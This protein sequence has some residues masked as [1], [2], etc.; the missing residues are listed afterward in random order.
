MRREEEAAKLH[1][2]TTVLNPLPVIRG[3]NHKVAAVAAT[4]DPMENVAAPAVRKAHERLS[5]KDLFGPKGG[6]TGEQATVVVKSKQACDSKRKAED[7]VVQ[8]RMKQR[9]LEAHVATIV[10]ADATGEALKG[11]AS[12]TT[13]LLEKLS[14][15][16]LAALIVRKGVNT[17]PK[18]K[19]ADLVLQ[20][21]VLWATK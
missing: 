21:G 20:V 14:M 10:L 5:S 1:I 15:K 19:K 13:E 2:A 9:G 16:A 18:G 12:W 7:Q 8:A 4:D 11:E 3:S 6:V 17:K